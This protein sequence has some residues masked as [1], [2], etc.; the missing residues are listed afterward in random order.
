MLHVRKAV[1]LGLCLISLPLTAAAPASAAGSAGSPVLFN[2]LEYQV[3]PATLRADARRYSVMVMWSDSARYVGQLH[4]LNPRLQILMYQNVPFST[5]SDQTGGMNCTTVPQDLAHPGWLARTASGAP[6]TA[7]GNYSTNVGNRGYQRACITHAIA[8]AK[9]RGFNGVFLDGVCAS[10]SWTVPSGVTAHPVQFPTD[11]AYQSAV[12]SLLSYAGPA[13]HA[14]GLKLYANVSA[15]DSAQWAK[16][17]G[18]L[19]GAM[20]ESWTDGGLGLAQQVPW[21]R[22]KLTNAAW[23]QAHGKYVLLHSYNRTETGNTYGLAAMLLVA[24]GRV[25]Y[26]TSTNYVTT[27]AWLPEY[28]TAQHLGAAR[29]R[30][31]VLRSG[32]YERVFAHG[33]VLVNP[34]RH[35][36]GS[37]ALRGRYS[38]THLR[39]VR[40]VSLAPLSAVILTRG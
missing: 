26:T 37:V 22:Q 25:S 11:A 21:W 33:I 3:T 39:H 23:S 32:A 7:G 6:V 30:Y 9:A 15:A 4:R 14:A 29:G 24:N 31:R 27:A 2:R 35:R 36:I 18:P 13:V 20:E 8:S 1:V 12:Y 5:A 28:T 19:D 34:S 38:G 16:W 10:F 17:N 40:S